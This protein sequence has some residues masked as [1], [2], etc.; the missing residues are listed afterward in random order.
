MAEKRLKR[1]PVYEEYLDGLFQGTTSVLAGLPD[2]VT[3]TDSYYDE[4]RQVFFFILQS[5][6]FDEVPEGEVIPIVD[7]ADFEVTDTLYE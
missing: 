6:D 3:V 2:D 7:P 1:F 4:A 5:D